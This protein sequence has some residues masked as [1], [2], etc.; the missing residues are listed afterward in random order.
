MSDITKKITYGELENKEYQALFKFTNGETV[1]GIINY[2]NGDVYMGEIKPDEKYDGK[3]DRR[4]HGY[5]KVF[6]KRGKVVDGEW[7]LGQVIGKSV[8][9]DKKGKRTVEVRGSDPSFRTILYSYYLTDDNKYGGDNYN[10]LYKDKFWEGDFKD[11]LRRG[12]LREQLFNGTVPTTVPSTSAQKSAPTKEKAPAKKNTAPKEPSASETPAVIETE[13]CIEEACE[14]DVDM[15]DDGFETMTDYYTACMDATSELV[16]NFDAQSSHD[17]ISIEDAVEHIIPFFNQVLFCFE[18][19]DPASATEFLAEILQVEANTLWEA[20]SKDG[21]FERDSLSLFEVCQSALRCAFVECVEIWDERIYIATLHFAYFLYKT[22]SEIDGYKCSCLFDNYLS[23]Y[24][25]QGL[26]KNNQSK[27]LAALFLARLYEY[28][29]EYVKLDENCDYYELEELCGDE[30]TRLLSADTVL[31]LNTRGCLIDP[32]NFV[33]CGDYSDQVD[34]NGIQTFTTN[35]GNTYR[36]YVDSDGLCHGWGKMCYADGNTYFGFFEHGYRQGFGINY[37]P[38]DGII[39]GNYENGYASGLCFERSLLVDDYEEFYPMTNTYFENGDGVPSPD[40][41][42]PSKGYRGAYSEDTQYFGYLDEDEY[43]HGFCILWTSSGD[44]LYHGEGMYEHGNL[45]FGL[46]TWLYTDESTTWA[47]GPFIS[48][49]DGTGYLLNTTPEHP[50]GQKGS[51]KVDR[52]EEIVTL[53][54]YDVGEF[55]N[56][57]LNGRGTR[58]FPGGLTISGYFING[59]VARIERV[60]LPNGEEADPAD[61]THY[62]SEKQSSEITWD[63]L[64]DMSTEEKDAFFAECP[65]LIV[66]K[67]VKKIPEYMFYK[68]ENL[69]GVYFNEDLEEIGK[70]AFAWCKNLGP[71]L[72]IPQSVYRIAESAFSVCNSIRTIY[73]PNNITVAK[74]GFMCGVTNV[75]FETDPPRGVILDNG[76][77]SDRDMVMSKDMIKKI[78]AINRRA[79]K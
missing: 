64:S 51:F 15:A 53:E 1:L 28:D 45:K 29:T 34:E 17:M 22:Y 58:V 24:I 20:F 75:I 4:R 19:H 27:N 47:Y 72:E 23:L 36:G 70:N 57:Y 21:M 10:G 78:K 31:S 18:E 61:Y 54:F 55:K 9:F 73:L 37:L 48:N 30:L 39:F 76:A 25:T 66:P 13:D 74:W 40:F 77:F 2:D 52:F 71:V 69:Q 7:H 33:V 79:F 63:E 44:P 12:E 35:D 59:G 8:T 6:P 3:R 14:Q 41:G 38:Y 68:C 32:K 50:I 49:S 56:N 43:A 16:D 46:R 42:Y 60:V 11:V 67:G 5:G 65:I 26:P 62:L